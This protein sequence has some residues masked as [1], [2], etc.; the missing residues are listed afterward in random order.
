MLITTVYNQA[1]AVITGCYY[2]AKGNRIDVEYMGS[3]L[4]CECY[5]NVVRQDNNGTNEVQ[6]VVNRV[7][8]RVETLWFN[9]PI[10][11]NLLFTVWNNAVNV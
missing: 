6:H 10:Q 9:A 3:T 8:N 11:S 4:E 2:D 7:V 1:N 5:I